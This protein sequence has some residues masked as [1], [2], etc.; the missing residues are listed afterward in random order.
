MKVLDS[1]LGNLPSLL[2]IAGIV[3]SFVP[4]AWLDLPVGNRQAGIAVAALGVVVLY[5]GW[6]AGW[7][8]GSDSESET[9]A[10]DPVTQTPTRTSGPG[11]IAH[12]YVPTVLFTIGVWLLLG[13]TRADPAFGFGPEPVE[14]PWGQL[15]V[16]GA[17][18]VVAAVLV[19]AL[20]HPRSPFF[21]TE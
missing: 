10:A 3:L 14:L 21:G 6:Y 12:R 15:P 20:T 2:I 9:S 19:F 16:L 1:A 7:Y 8:E 5:V 17:A 4:S 18:F 11:E 13:Q